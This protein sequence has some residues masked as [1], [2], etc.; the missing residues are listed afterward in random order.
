VS[1]SLDAALEALAGRRAAAVSVWLGGVNGRRWFGRDTELVHPAAST[2]KLPLVIALHRAADAGALRLSDEIVVRTTLDSQV[3]GLTYD[4]T[5]DYDND[6]QPW[7]RVGDRVALGWLAERAIVRSSNL[8][9]NLLIDRLGIDPVNAVY[10]DA[11]A[12]ASRVERGIQDEPAIAEG[13]SNRVTAADLAAV[14]GALA[15]RQIAAP[16]SCERI[17]DLLARCEHDTAAAAGLPDGTYFAHK[18]GWFEGVA[19]DVGIVRQAGEPP[20]VLAVL[21]GADL[22]EAAADR[23]VADI[24]ALCWTHRHD[25]AAVEDREAIR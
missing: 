6:D 15:R 8:A 23:L 10:S 13:R 1:T 2:M 18:T 7:E 19:H 16:D 4:V 12:T 9:T 3:R 20:F 11:G 25:V 21:T 14:L 17:E 24:A 22:D 5:Q